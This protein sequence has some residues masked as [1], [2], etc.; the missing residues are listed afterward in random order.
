[1]LFPVVVLYTFYMTLALLYSKNNIYKRKFLTLWFIFIM[2]KMNFV[3]FSSHCMCNLFRWRIH[4]WF[5]QVQ[6]LVLK[7]PALR[8]MLSIFTL[9]M[10]PLVPSLLYCCGTTYNWCWNANR[11]GNDIS[12]ATLRECCCSHGWHYCTNERW[13]WLLLCEA[14]IRFSENKDIGADDAHYVITAT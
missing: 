1:M 7:H 9:R 5:V 4:H 10:S 8:V 12:S 14:S 3:K 2:Q 6:V 13:S 11:S